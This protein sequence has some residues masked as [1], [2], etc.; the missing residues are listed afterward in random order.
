MKRTLT[1]DYTLGEGFLV[2]Y[3]DGLRSGTAV[4][5]RCPACGRVAL[6][7][8]PVCTCGAHD[9]VIM[10][11]P[12]LATVLWR[13]TGSDGDV[14]LVRFDGADSNALA[15]LDGFARQARGRI[16]ASAEAALVLIPE[17]GS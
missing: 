17:A 3:L 5:S 1:L 6:P 13:S 8:E 16:T 4:A 10:A 15:R 11:L 9:P 2:S 12:G 14:A 7:P